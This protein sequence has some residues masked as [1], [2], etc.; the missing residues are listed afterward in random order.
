M[1]YKMEGNIWWRGKPRVLMN[2]TF[3]LLGSCNEADAGQLPD[4]GHH[5]EVWSTGS[6]ETTPLPEWNDA[7]KEEKSIKRRWSKNEGDF[8]NER[9]TIIRI[10][11]LRTHRTHSTQTHS[12]FVRALQSAYKTENGARNWE[13]GIQSRPRKRGGVKQFFPWFQDWQVGIPDDYG[14]LKSRMNMN[15]QVLSS[16][17][18]NKV[19][20][21]RVRA[22]RDC[23]LTTR[24][25]RCMRSRPSWD[26]R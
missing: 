5:M 2:M 19:F 15:I 4:Q 9:E 17:M 22:S 14:R 11:H 20:S 6:K 24:A 16:T 25:S 18:C 7:Q 3:T 13:Y 26:F 12:L 10:P 1:I 8:V 23:G 21:H